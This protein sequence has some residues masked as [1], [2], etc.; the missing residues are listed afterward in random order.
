MI[1][2]KQKD[3]N[4]MTVNELTKLMAGPSQINRKNAAKVLVVRVK[5]NPESFKKHIPD[6]VD[7]LSRP[8]A[9]TR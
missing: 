4:D 6:F 3:Y 9:Q 8:E 1:E 7:A 2:K 5:E